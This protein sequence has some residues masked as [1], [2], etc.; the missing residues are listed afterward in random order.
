M[1]CPACGSQLEKMS[2]DNIKVDVCRRGCGG[3]WFDRFELDRMDEAHEAA[4]ERLLELDVE[5]H[6]K[7]ARSKKRSCPKCDGLLMMRH[8]F[9]V[10]KKVEV[11]ECPGCAG[12]WLD[13]DELRKIRNEFAT[14]EEREKAANRYFTELF[15]EDIKRTKTESDERLKKARKFARLFRFICPTYYIPGK[16]SGGAY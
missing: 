13:G 3:I 14:E 6:A 11:D 1:K 10:R 4:G 9:S 2:V 15:E 7:V 12:V 5:F 8:Y 16:Q